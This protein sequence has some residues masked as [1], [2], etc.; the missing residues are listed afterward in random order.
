[1]LGLSLDGEI[2]FAANAAPVLGY[3]DEELIGRPVQTVVPSSPVWLPANG[4]CSELMVELPCRRKNGSEFLAELSLSSIQTRVGRQICASLREAPEWHRA[5]VTRNVLAFVAES[6]SDAVISA[7]IDGVITYWNPAAETLYGYGAAEML[8]RRTDILYLSGAAERAAIAERLAQGR[9]LRLRHAPR[10]RNDGTTVWVDVTMTPIA[11]ADGLVV[12]GA[13]LATPAHHRPDARPDAL[14]HTRF[15]DGLGH[16]AGGIA[17]DFNNLMGVIGGNAEFI[18]Q[19]AEDLADLVPEERRAA[20]VGEAMAIQESVR[21]AARLTRQLLAFGGRTVARP[22]AADVNDIV[23]GLRS[24][25]LDTLGD[26]IPVRLRLADVLPRVMA[27]TAQIEHLVIGAV[28]N[29]RDAMPAGGNLSI[30]TAD[31]TV[32]EVYAKQRGARPGRYVRLRVSDTGAGMTKDVLAHAFEPF[33]TTKPPGQGTGL[34]L[35][36]IY[37]IAARHDGHVAIYSEPDRGTTLSVLLPAVDAF[38]AEPA[39]PATAGRREDGDRRRTILVVDDEEPLRDLAARILAR[40]GHTVLVAA[41]GPA[42][43]ELA[44]THQ[45]AIDLLLTDVV[46]PRMLGKELA[47][48]FAAAWPDVPVLYM[49]GYAQPVLTERGTLG[50][51]TTLLEKPFTEAELRATVLRC[52]RRPT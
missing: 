23:R 52:A 16:L 26:R 18:Q 36:T 8:G 51:D 43:L 32:D 31:V 47:E 41:D 25:L 5:E 4:P 21:R 39:R 28:A 27:D 40:D 38:P 24:R 7:T 1:M 42:A 2:T 9:V 6:S 30:D 22:Q 37:G 49:S 17:H 12:G 34:G 19:D 29:A 33:F 44:R 3:A 14:E 11:D 35:S 20:I 10:L 48:Q 15:L 50:P 13:S 45:G 46:M